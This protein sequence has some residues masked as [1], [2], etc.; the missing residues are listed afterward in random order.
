LNSNELTKKDIQFLQD[1]FV[2]EYVN[3]TNRVDDSKTVHTKIWF[4]VVYELLSSKKLISNKE[5]TD[6]TIKHPDLLLN[7]R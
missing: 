3:H 5:Q 1:R 7:P 4:T 6:S 2:E